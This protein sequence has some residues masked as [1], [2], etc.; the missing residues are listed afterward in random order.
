MS[1]QMVPPEQGEEAPPALGAKPYDIQSCAHN[2][3]T[4]LEKLATELGKADVDPEVI[5]AVS[6]YADD[7]E[8]IAKSYSKLMD[9]AQQAQ[10][11]GP[12]PT[13]ADATE[14]LASDVRQA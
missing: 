12:R 5:K 4:A 8:K 14:G 1:D 6:G 2:A 11:A 10:P 7:M 9:K 13:M 3:Q